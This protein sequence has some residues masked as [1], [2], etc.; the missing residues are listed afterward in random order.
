MPEDILLPGRSRQETA[1]AQEPAPGIKLKILVL[2]THVWRGGRAGGAETHTLQLMK[3]L[4]LRGHE[5]FFVAASGKGGV[6]ATPPGVTA[7]YRL[8]FQS[9]NPFDKVAAYR[10]LK[11]IV[12]RHE[13]DLLHAH[14]RTGLSLIH[15]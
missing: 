8:P 2:F 13:I 4:S 1:R 9:L 15:I 12:V 3:E 5:I 10:Q 14:H 11:E 7:E 6:Y